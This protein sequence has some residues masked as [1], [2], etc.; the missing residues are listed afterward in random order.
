MLRYVALSFLILLM[1]T[2]IGCTAIGM[3][4]GNSIDEKRSREYKAIIANDG[5]NCEEGDIVKVKTNTGEYYSGT[6]IEIIPAKY[7]ILSSKE[8]GATFHKEFGMSYIIEWATIYEITVKDK[9]HTNLIGLAG[10][11][12]IIDILVF[13]S[14]YN[15]DLP[16]EGKR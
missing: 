1:L 15:L 8:K 9:K 6:I 16:G 11:G 3:G 2:T 5:C 12:L 14:L 7:L 4:I 13:S 10:I